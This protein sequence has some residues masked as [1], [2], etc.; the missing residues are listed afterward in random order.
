MAAD[1]ARY[2]S[3][4]ILEEQEENGETGRGDYANREPPE[5][6]AKSPFGV[7]VREEGR[8]RS[9][10][11]ERKEGEIERRKKESGR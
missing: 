3:A 8:K 9:P 5:G 11:L 10:V 1:V 6:E 4:T 2:R 7:L